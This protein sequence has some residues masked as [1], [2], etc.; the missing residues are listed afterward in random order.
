MEEAP[1]E[2]SSTEFPKLSFEN[3]DSAVCSGKLWFPLHKERFEQK[4]KGTGA[5]MDCGSSRNMS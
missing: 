5:S 4:V 3:V 2:T 1:R